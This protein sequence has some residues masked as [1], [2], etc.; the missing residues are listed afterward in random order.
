MKKNTVVLGLGNPLMADE[1]IGG[2]LIEKFLTCRDDFP[3][4]EFIDAGTGGMSLL[5]LIADRKKA[6]IIDCAYM[7][8]PAGTIKRFTPDQVE[9]VKKLAHQSLHEADILK[10]IDIAKQLGTCPPKIVIFGIEPETIAAEQ[11]LSETLLVK[12]T[13]YIAAIAKELTALD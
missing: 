5:H 7:H 4:I 13:K 2:F 1:G 3:D 8:T 11:K 12:A 6:V 9:S 10:I